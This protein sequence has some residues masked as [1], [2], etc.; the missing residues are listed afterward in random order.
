MDKEHKFNI[1]ILNFY[2]Y[3]FFKTWI[4]FLSHDFIQLRVWINSYLKVDTNVQLAGNTKFDKV[5]NYFIIS[6]LET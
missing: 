4:M 2:P 6:I 5:Y 3:M 1:I